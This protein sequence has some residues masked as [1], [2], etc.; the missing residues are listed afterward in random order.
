MVAMRS[1]MTRLSY[2][3]LLARAPRGYTS[4]PQAAQLRVL[5]LDPR[6]P[7][8]QVGELD[9]SRRLAASLACASKIR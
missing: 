3:P 7:V 5:A 4:A 9:S 1:R 8:L 6:Q 2:L